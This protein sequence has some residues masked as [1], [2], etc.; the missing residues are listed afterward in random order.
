VQDVRDLE[1]AGDGVLFEV[2][3]VA[4]LIRKALEDIL[5]GVN[6]KRC[7]ALDGEAPGLQ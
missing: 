4:L 2:A 3:D 5:E 6:L 7:E 1:E